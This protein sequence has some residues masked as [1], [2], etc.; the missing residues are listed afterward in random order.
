MSLPSPKGGTILSLLEYPASPKL[1]KPAIYLYWLLPSPCGCAP[2]RHL[3]SLLTLFHLLSRLHSLPEASTALGPSTGHCQPSWL[4]FSLPLAYL[5]SFI[6]SGPFSSGAQ[7]NAVHP[8]LPPLLTPS[9]TAPIAP[10]SDPVM[11]HARP[12]RPSNCTDTVLF[13]LLPTNPSQQSRVGFKAL[14]LLSALFHLVPCFPPEPA[15]QTEVPGPF[16]STAC[17][18]LCTLCCS[19]CLLGLDL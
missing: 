2:S 19:P 15:S 12:P 7:N 5:N 8:S 1:P 11:H 14:L 16:H 6:F 4:F 9:T 3:F 18:I 17:S 10:A 13:T